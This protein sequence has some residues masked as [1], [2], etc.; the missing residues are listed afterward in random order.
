MSHL[1]LKRCPVALVPA[2]PGPRPL[3][4]SHRVSLGPDCP[5]LE[6]GAGHMARLADGAAEAR[7]GSTAVLSTVCRGRVTSPGFLPLTVDYRLVLELCV[8]HVYS[9]VIN[10][11]LDK[12]LPRRAGCR[13][14][15][16]GGSW[17]PAREKYLLAE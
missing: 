15:C 3:R 10:D 7:L 5:P 8:L 2:P 13:L 4:F 14:T 9:R 17:A 6:L 11:A 16:Y 12:K 1:L